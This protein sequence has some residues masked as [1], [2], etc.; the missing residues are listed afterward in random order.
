M[1]RKNLPVITLVPPEPDFS[2][3]SKELCAL[4]KAAMESKMESLSLKAGE[5][6]AVYDKINEKLSLPKGG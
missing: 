4:H 3:L 5:K 1:R 2:F 6:A